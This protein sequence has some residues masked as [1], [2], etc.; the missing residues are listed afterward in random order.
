MKVRD[1]AQGLK[2]VLDPAGPLGEI[3]SPSDVYKQRAGLPVSA[4]HVQRDSGFV[5]VNPAT[6]APV[7]FVAAV[8]AT[9]PASRVRLVSRYIEEHW[10]PV[11]E[12]TTSKNY[13]EI[14]RASQTLVGWTVTQRPRSP[15]CDCLQATLEMDHDGTLVHRQCGRARNRVADEDFREHVLSL[16]IAPS[17]A[18]YDGFYPTI[19]GSDSV[20]TASGPAKGGTRIRHGRREW[21]E[22]TKGW[23]VWDK[24]V[25]KEREKAYAAEQQKWI[26]GV[27]ERVVKANRQMLPRNI[28]QL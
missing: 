13:A 9:P 2:N 8:G 23:V 15:L 25:V 26:T 7:R 24:G 19:P 11:Y 14:I 12:K 28:G 5:P 27:R 21:R 10:A 6:L 1:L 3:V 18:F 22:K 17:D 20:M 4:P 16:Q